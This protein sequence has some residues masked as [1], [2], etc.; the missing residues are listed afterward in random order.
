MEHDSI[1]RLEKVTAG[2]SGQSVFRNLSLAFPPGCFVGLVGPSG[3]GKSTLLKTIL[4]VVQ[5]SQG[6]I[7]IGNRPLTPGRVASEIGYV[8]QLEMVDWNF[9]VTVGQVVMMGRMRN[10]G[11]MPWASRNDRLAMEDMLERLGLG[12]LA[13]RHIR[14][15]SGGQQQRVFLARAL[16]SQPKLLLLDEPTSGVDV[17]TRNDVL[18]L[19]YEINRQGIA[20]ILTTHDL[21][22][23][24]SLLPYL[25]CMNGGIIAQGKVEE[26]FNPEVLNRTYNSDMQ[27]IYH[28]GKPVVIDRIKPVISG[29]IPSKRKLKSKVGE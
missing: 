6:E 7:F 21:N 14:E 10:M 22:S 12:G 17:K 20:L 15:L 11:L 27:V 28:D 3:S 8:P 16:I 26:V 1:V 4:G 18:E 5:P 29:I 19:L 23:V 24:A 9:P 2:Y 13:G 25:V